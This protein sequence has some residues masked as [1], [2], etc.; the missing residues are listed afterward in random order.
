MPIILVANKTDQK[1]DRM[2][3]TEEGRLRS[4]EM[5]CSCFHEISVRENVD[6]VQRVFVDACRWWRIISKYPKLKRS[7]S[8]S[9]KMTMGIKLQNDN[10]SEMI[11]SRLHQL[12]CDSYEDKRRL[13]LTFGRSRSALQED[14]PPDESELSDTLEPFRSRAQTDGQILRK[15]PAIGS[16]YLGSN[17]RNSISQRG[18]VSY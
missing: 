10:E 5:G 15:K 11:I 13:I 2:V 4:A 7:T 1:E 9:L 3:S 18:H 14:K 8:E 17:R 12:C 16:A 6:D